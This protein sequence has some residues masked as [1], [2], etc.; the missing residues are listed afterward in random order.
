[1]SAE[2]LGSESAEGWHRD[3]YLVHEDRW[4][5][6]GQPTKLVR[7]HGAE[8]YDPP[9]PGLPKTG[10]VKL[11][12]NLPRPDDPDAGKPRRRFIDVNPGIPWDP[13]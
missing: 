8:S 11:P 12:W 3:P 4:Y 9:P 6:D 10:L 7:D 1:M 5:S 13:I 2:D